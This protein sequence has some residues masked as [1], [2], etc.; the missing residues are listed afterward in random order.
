MGTVDCLV[1]HQGEVLG[2]PGVLLV[3][4]EVLLEVLEVPEVQMNG[5]VLGVQKN[6]V[7]EDPERP[8]DQ[9]DQSGQMRKVALRDS[10]QVVRSEGH[11]QEAKS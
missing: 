10:G 9:L 7:L 11:D 1:Q 6:E 2:V 4:P 3:V 5:V 8:K